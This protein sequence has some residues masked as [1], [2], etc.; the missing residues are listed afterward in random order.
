MQV[1]SSLAPKTWRCLR[2]AALPILFPLRPRNRHLA[3]P[4]TTRFC[5]SGDLAQIAAEGVA[6]RCPKTAELLALYWQI[7]GNFFLFFLL[8][9][10][11]LPLGPIK[12]SPLKSKWSACRAA[13]AAHSGWRFGDCRRANLDFDT[14]LIRA[15]GSAWCRRARLSE[16]LAGAWQKRCPPAEDYK[17]TGNF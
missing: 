2:S 13:C 8:C 11:T 3:S 15:L 12:L 6:E 1:R 10:L 16:Q 9:I 7:I 17:R 14:G 5:A 4:L